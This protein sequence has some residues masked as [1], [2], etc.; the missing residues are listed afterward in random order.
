MNKLKNGV[1]SLSN[2]NAE[3]FIMF[4][5]TPKK[6]VGRENENRTDRIMAII[7]S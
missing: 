4:S 5:L 2:S 6:N 1:S 7:C 3:G